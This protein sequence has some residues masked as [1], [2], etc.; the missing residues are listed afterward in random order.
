[1]YHKIVQT[2]TKVCNSTFSNIEEVKKPGGK[3]RIGIDYIRIIA[4]TISRW[5]ESVEVLVEGAGMVLGEPTLLPL[6]DD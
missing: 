6:T 3:G 1:L 4:D 5:I 2:I